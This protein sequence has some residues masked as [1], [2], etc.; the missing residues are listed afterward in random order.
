M[1]AGV[2][3]GMSVDVGA[4]ACVDMG[5]VGGLAAWTGA[6]GAAGAQ[7]ITRIMLPNRQLRI[8]HIVFPFTLS[9]HE[10]T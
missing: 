1:G 3:V 7:D 2:G 6:A 8:N 10:Q 9:P 5:V 4:G